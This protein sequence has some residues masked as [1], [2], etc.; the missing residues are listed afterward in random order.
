VRDGGGWHLDGVKDCVPAAHLAGAIVVPAST[1]DGR[2]GLF[3]VEPSTPGVTLERQVATNKEPQARL[4]LAGARV[5]ADSVL[6]DPE[7][8]R[9]MVDWLL[10]RALLGLCALE[11][12]VAER[13]LRI[14]AQYTAERRQFDR[15]IA[16]FQ[17]VQ[18]RAADAWIDVEA[19]RLTTW[20]AAWR[21][22][23]GL[24]PREEGM[25]AKFWAAEA[26]H[27]HLLAAPHPARAV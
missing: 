4:T 10:D 21:L 9:A 24:P 16:S 26:G 13:A 22:D 17:A 12:G 5:A 23:R 20:Q 2:V 3:L 15:P 27:R 7:G 1:G 8:G 6:G 11:L 18:Q 19:I 25:V 14:T